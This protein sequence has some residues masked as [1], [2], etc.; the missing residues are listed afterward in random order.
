MWMLTSRIGRPVRACQS[1]T[2]IWRSST[3]SRR[4]VHSGSRSA[5]GMRHE[6]AKMDDREG[7]EEVRRPGVHVLHELGIQAVAGRAAVAGVGTRAGDEDA[8]DDRDKVTTVV[9]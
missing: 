6:P 9:R 7:E 2:A 5:R 8:D 3:A 1:P 4:P